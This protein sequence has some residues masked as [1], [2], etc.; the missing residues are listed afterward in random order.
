MRTYK[1]RKCIKGKAQEA[2]GGTTDA[3]GRKMAVRSTGGGRAADSL[4][5]E[6]REECAQ[7]LRFRAPAPRDRH[8]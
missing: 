2:P 7:G 6:M 3:H 1:V 5:D 8:R 4:A